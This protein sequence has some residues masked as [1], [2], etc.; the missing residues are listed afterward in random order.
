MAEHQVTG[1]GVSVHIGYRSPLGDLLLSLTEV[2][3]QLALCDEL[4]VD[5]LLYLLV[6]P[7]FLVEHRAL[8]RGRKLGISLDLG[9]GLFLL[10]WQH[11]SF[12][13]NVEGGQLIEGGLHG[14]RE[15]LAQAIPP[16]LIERVVMLPPGVV[17]ILLKRT[18]IRVFLICQWHFLM[19]SRMLYEE[20]GAL[21][22]ELLVDL[23]GEVESVLE[24]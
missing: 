18:F 22:L 5:Y 14:H 1:V 9:I 21:L 20:L 8:Q 11:I 17:R 10:A 16:G 2:G 12:L 23:A 24:G 4:H 3:L 15:I 7:L 6:V 19:L 13:H